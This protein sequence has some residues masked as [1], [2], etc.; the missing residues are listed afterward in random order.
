MVEALGTAGVVAVV[1]ALWR[2]S[3]EHSGMRVA[4][5]KG[6]SQIVDQIKGLR[7]E[8]RRDIEHLENVIEDHEHRIRKL[9]QD[10]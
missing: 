5:D 4:L 6:M 9:E 1:G 2:L 7:I 3:N 8:L 10:S